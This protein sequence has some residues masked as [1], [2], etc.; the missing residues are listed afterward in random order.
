MSAERRP[1]Q[2]IRMYGDRRDDGRIQIS[3]TLPVPASGRAKEAARRLCEKMGLTNIL[4]ATME[5]AGSSFSFFVVYAT[6]S[7]SVDFAE[8]EVPEV[9]APHWSAKQIN[10]IIK[11][12][13]GRKVVVVGAC[14]GSDAHT[15]GI[16][17]ILNMKGYA[18]DK[19]LEAYP[20]FDAYNLGAQV[21]NAALLARAGE[22]KADAVLVSQII[23]QRDVHKENSRQLTELA[24]KQGLR[25]LLLVLGGPRID[26][27]LAKELG[28][29]AGFGPGTRPSQV[30]SYILQELLQKLGVSVNE[31][32][33]RIADVH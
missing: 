32:E 29:D 2:P 30:A 1:P 16:D 7:V 10:S 14:T 24:R 4:V 20:W 11:Q 28:Y 26:H 15:V 17:A 18:G 19:G 6:T 25:D 31:A 33:A 22:L 21:D 8:I 5:P 12:L 27:K 9:S 13:V 23:T 3:F